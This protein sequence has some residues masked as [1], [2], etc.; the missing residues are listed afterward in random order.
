MQRPR[1]GVHNG[2]VY[3]EP[4][5]EDGGAKIGRTTVRKL[6]GGWSEFHHQTLAG[7]RSEVGRASVGGWGPVGGGFG[8]GRGRKASPEPH[9]HPTATA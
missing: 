6:A 7:G 1:A 8:A 5:R 4:A 2:R 3:V 9:G